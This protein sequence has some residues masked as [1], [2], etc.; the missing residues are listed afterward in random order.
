M[1]EHIKILL[2][3]DN[4]GDALLIKEALKDS[5]YADAKLFVAETLKEALAFSEENILLV[6]TDLGLPDSDGLETVKNIHEYFPDSALIVLTGLEDTRI[7][8]ATLREGAQNFLNKNE[9]DGKVLDKT[10]RFSLERHEILQKLKSVDKELIQS[11]FLLEKAQE[12]SHMGSWSADLINETAKWSDE[13]QRIFGLK[14]GE[15]DGRASTFFSMIHLEDAALI[16]KEIENSAREKRLFDITHRIVR[17]NGERRWVHS[18]AEIFFNETGKPENLIGSIQ[19]ITEM[20]E[21]EEKIIKANRL[22][23][24]ISAINQSIVHIKNE[25]ELLDNACKIAI[26]IGEFKTTWIGLLDKNKRLNIVS[27][28]GDEGIR[29]ELQKFSGLD[30]TSPEL[31]P[32]PIGK[33]LISGKYEVKNDAQNDSDMKQFKEVLIQYGIKSTISFPLKKSDKVIGVFGFQS[34]KENF[35]D[36]VEITLL[37]EAAGDISFALEVFEKE[38]QRVDAEKDRVRSEIKLK[39][40]QAIAMVGSFEIDMKNNG[41]YWSDEMFHLLGYEKDEIVPMSE[42]FLSMVHPE[43][44]E[45]VNRSFNETF[46]TFQNSSS[47]FRIIDKNKVEKHAY[48]QWKFEFDKNKNPIRLAG[49]VQ[50][51]TCRKQAEHEREKILT[52]LTHRYNE[53]MQF[54]YIVSHNLRAPLVN[55]MG[56]TNLF[57]LEDDLEKKEQTIRFIQETALKMDEVIHDLSSILALKTTLNERRELINLKEII[58]ATNRTLA[59]QINNAKATVNVFIPDEVNNFMSIKAYIESIFYNLISNAIKY[60][61]P[62]RSAI[63]TIEASKQESE[64]IIK[65]SDNGIGVNLELHKDKIFGLYSRFNSEREGKGL[66]LYMV[67]TQIESLGGNIELESEVDRGSTFIIK[68]KMN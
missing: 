58:L 14:P 12:V 53:L 9:V 51:I 35:F 60:S 29:K 40:A 62:K 19:D 27:T 31:S 64:I 11:K 16:N 43:D 38:K 63:I 65:I 36:E 26:G 3:E 10:I 59:T 68:L 32:T 25:Q 55:I 17:R 21:A 33:V 52:D 20:K 45:N 7:A 56:L 46:Q 67:K 44:S 39:E 15:F 57:S 30:F 42:T 50:N 28:D 5:S 1:N 47:E 49:I 22:Y 18:Q 37:D 66:G 6:L 2:V 48:C 13:A 61:S 23:A 54:N 41:L 34:V 4:P 8:L 24:F